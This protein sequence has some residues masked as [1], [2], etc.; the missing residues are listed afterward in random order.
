MAEEDNSQGDSNGQ[1]STQSGGSELPERIQK[2][3]KSMGLQDKI[4]LIGS[5]VL[6]LLS[7]FNWFGSNFGGA[8]GWHDYH[9]LGLLACIGAIAVTLLKMENPNWLQASLAVAAFGL[10]PFAYWLR[11]SSFGKSEGEG[12]MRML[13]RSSSF[14]LSLTFIFWLAFIASLAAAVGAGW[15]LFEGT[16]KQ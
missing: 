7:F 4:V 1:G 9:V 8:N 10:G 5:A 13:F 2:N 14:G 15:K 11:V 6:L 3:L 16:Q 12:A